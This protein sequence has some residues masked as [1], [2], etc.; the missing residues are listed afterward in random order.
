V[1]PTHGDDAL[2]Q[3]YIVNEVLAAE[4]PELV[5]ALADVAVVDRVGPGLAR[6]LTGRADAGDLLRRAETRGLFVTSLPTPGSFEVHALVRAAL[7]AEA[8]ATAP[9]RL[10][11]RHARAAR[12][13]EEGGETVLA[14]EHWLRA[15]RP[16]E[17]LRLL[18][19]E[20]SSLYDAGREAVV[21][22]AIAAIPDEV[23]SA[24][25]GARLD[26]AWCHLLVDRQRF[27]DLVEELTWWADRP[28]TD[29]GLRP[30]VT[31]LQSVRATVSGR[32]S[33]G[34][35]LARQ[36]MTT[37]GDGWWRDPLGRF[38]WNMVACDVALSERWD[39]AGD[40]VREAEFALSADPER[41]LAL[42]GTRALGI[43]LAGQ[44]VDALRV[45]AAVRRAATVTE[46]TFLRFELGVA[47]AIAHREMG[48]RSRA[49]GELEAH[50]GTP[51]GTL[52]YCQV[53]AGAELVQAYLDHGDDV[54]AREELRKL[55]ALVKAEA[56]GPEGVSRVARAGTL[57]ALADGSIGEARRW[58]G[59]VDDPFWTRV[60]AARIHL[61][62]GAPGDAVT[63]LDRAVPRGVRHQ[64]VAAVLRALALQDREESLHQVAD[65]VDLAAAVG[66]L[67]TVAS[68]GPEVVQLVERVADRAPEEWMHRLRRAAVPVGHVDVAAG[69]P[70]AT[71]TGRERDV[72][73][74]LAGRLTVRE[75]ATELYVSPNTLKFHLKTIYRKLGVGSRAEAAEVA[76]HMVAV[77]PRARSPR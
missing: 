37:M 18:A 9:D 47:E 44:P 51:G 31:M 75:I 57:V 55:E 52:L 38:G 72:L 43:A 63:I 48:D 58:T 53:I 46:M 39:D 67:Q 41:R 35:M 45:S 14:L 68:E 20:H 59:L 76:R 62:E 1:A 25:L 40:D 54:A 4:E 74:L 13:Y 70:V 8:T 49:L 24:D 60:C 26:F 50:A 73:R 15:D 2:I 34:G 21:L 28:S 42:E 33:D 36:A 65:A 22:R 23:A 32:W 56:F 69:D 11:A 6:A 29:A 10:V 77:H 3:A 19:A 64:V 27:I 12:W 7:V 61:A 71:L 16:R 5:A 30:R 66:L 17:A